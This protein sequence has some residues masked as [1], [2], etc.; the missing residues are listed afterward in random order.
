MV[1]LK[2]TVEDVEDLMHNEHQHGPLQ[3]IFAAATFVARLKEM[4][5]RLTELQ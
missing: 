5:S 4:K 3:A 2:I 1:E